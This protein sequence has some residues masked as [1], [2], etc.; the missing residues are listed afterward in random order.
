MSVCQFIV[1]ITGTAASF[2]NLAAQKA[3]IAFVCI[4]IFFFASSWGP[5][6]FELFT[7]LFHISVTNH[8][9]SRMGGYRRV[10]STQGSRQGFVHDHRQ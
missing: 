8:F 1:A 5:G 4:Y 9:L 3:A 10:V 2:E 7:P 6:T